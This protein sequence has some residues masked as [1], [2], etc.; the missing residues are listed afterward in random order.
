VKGWNDLVD[1]ALK[2]NPEDF[3]EELRKVAKEFNWEIEEKKLLDLYASAK[4]QK[5]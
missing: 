1:R 4:E 3:S 5:D 2:S